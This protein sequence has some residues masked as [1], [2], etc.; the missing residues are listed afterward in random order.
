MPCYEESKDNFFYFTSIV[1]QNQHNH[2]VKI[3]L[4]YIELGAIRHKKYILIIGRL[5][6]FHQN[7]RKLLSCINYGSENDKIFKN[8]PKM[9]SKNT[10]IL[11]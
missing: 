7:Q 1:H 2:E 10:T 11:F 6:G 8:D 3:D 4:N 5:V 9:A